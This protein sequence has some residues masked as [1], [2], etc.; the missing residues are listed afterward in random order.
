MSDI[1]PFLVPPPDDPVINHP[2][3]FSAPP[4]ENFV[5]HSIPQDA[6]IPFSQE[7]AKA[8]QK[9]A[10]S[11]AYHVIDHFGPQFKAQN[12]ALIQQ[13]AT[14]EKIAQA[15]AIQSDQAIKQANAAEER[16]AL[17]KEQV[18]NLSSIAADA[19]SQAVTV[20]KEL[21]VQ[22]EQLALARSEAEGAKKDAFWSKV[23]SVVSII[24]SIIVLIK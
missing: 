16:L 4:C 5:S 17:F 6:Q 14:L 9:A 11:D 1:K 21:E 7:D 22:K 3:M 24:I 15:A 18:E 19:K 2:E 12:A 10:L 13:V 8:I 20:S 23:F